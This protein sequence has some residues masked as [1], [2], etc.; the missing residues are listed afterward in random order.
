M[1]TICFLSNA[2]QSD[3]PLAESKIISHKVYETNRNT[4]LPL[5]GLNCFVPEGCSVKGDLFYFHSFNQ[6]GKTKAR[7]SPIFPRRG[8]SLSQESGKSFEQAAQ[9][10]ITYILE[11]CIEKITKLRRVL[12]TMVA[13]HIK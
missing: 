8:F 12:L 13:V 6:S 3:L 9:I 11:I 5:L 10:F 2:L 1:L 7:V 4:L